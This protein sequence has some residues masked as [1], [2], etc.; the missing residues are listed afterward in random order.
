M[1]YLNSLYLS[2][3]IWAFYLTTYFS[4]ISNFRLVLNVVRFL[5]GNSPACEFY[6]P[7]FR[8]TLFHLHRQVGM[9]NF[10]IPTCL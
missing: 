10:F 1:D 5:L 9:N 2:I 7:T 6:L 3:Y 4:Y 8:N